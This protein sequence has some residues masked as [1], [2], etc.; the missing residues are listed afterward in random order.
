MVFP[1]FFVHHSKKILDHLL[2]LMQ[3]KGQ[4]M[5]ADA[6]AKKQIEGGLFL[7]CD[8]G[9]GGG[10]TTTVASLKTRLEK[11]GYEVLTTHEPGA[12]KLGHYL[13]K[14][15]IDP[16]LANGEVD[17]LESLLIFS[18][19]RHAHIRQIIAPALAAGKIVITDRYVYSALVYQAIEGVPESVI[20]TLNTVATGGL[21]PARTYWL[22]VSPQI[23]LSRIASQARPE[24]N[25]NDSAAL[26]FHQQ[27][28]AGFRKLY[29]AWPGQIVRI[30]ADASKEQ[31]T[32]TIYDD[33]QQLLPS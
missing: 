9:E 3:F 21:L 30:D 27:V 11:L 2:N 25:K 4:P 1:P 33:L 10:K 26:S 20:E 15:V 12:T 7:V 24:A 5:N 18:A 29:E 31:V 13:R 6:Q 8:G 23:S 22:D 32:Q 17:G 19:D 14:I 28:Q 16:Q